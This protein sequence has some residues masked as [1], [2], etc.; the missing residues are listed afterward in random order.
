VARVPELPHR[1]CTSTHGC[2]CRYEPV[3]ETYEDL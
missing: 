2:R 3:L 1:E